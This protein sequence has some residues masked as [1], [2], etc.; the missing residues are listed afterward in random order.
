[1]GKARTNKPV[2]ITYQTR[3]LAKEGGINSTATLLFG[4]KVYL[5]PNKIIFWVMKR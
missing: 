5:I 1:M 4:S 3:R 2:L